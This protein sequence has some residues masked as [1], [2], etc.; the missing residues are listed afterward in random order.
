MS[1][2]LNPTMARAMGS[3]DQLGFEWGKTSLKLKDLANS[4]FGILSQVIAGKQGTQTAVNSSGQLVPVNP[5]QGQYGGN[6][7]QQ[8]SPNAY[9][10]PNANNPISPGEGAGK[11]AVN[12]G[13]GVLDEIAESFGVS[14]ATLGIGA[15]IALGL[16][17]MQPGKK[18]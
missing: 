16:Y 1:R 17:L 12:A 7:Y 8:Q 5:G 4:G 9:S 18:R 15:A 2:A 3:R 11:R 13:S 10:Q 6:R 14:T